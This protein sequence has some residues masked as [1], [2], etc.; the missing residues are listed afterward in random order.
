M[1]HTGQRPQAIVT[2]LTYNVGPS[3]DSSSH[4]VFQ[5]LPAPRPHHVRTTTVSRDRDHCGWSFCEQEPLGFNS[6]ALLRLADIRLNAN[7]GPNR[8]LVTRDPMRI[9]HAFTNGKIHVS[10]RSPH[11]DR[12]I[13]QCIH[14]LSVPVRV[15]ITFV[16]RIQTL[17]WSI[18]HSL[19]CHSSELFPSYLLV[20][21]PLSPVERFECCSFSSLN[22]LQ[23]AHEVLVDVSRQ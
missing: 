12:A 5:R 13:L 22:C 18:Q 14:A 6:T 9:V 16:A 17:N 20:R 19:G 2:F 4:P 10:K 15:G 1:P 8:Q 7:L 21:D 11:L 3:N 23:E